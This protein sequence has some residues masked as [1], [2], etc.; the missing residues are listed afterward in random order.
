MDCAAGR[1]DA[2][3]D[4]L[5]RLD[6]VKHSLKTIL[7]Q[8]NESDFIALIQFSDDANLVGEIL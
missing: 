6:L 3:C 5:S 1:S 2:E 8:L 4:G 7:N